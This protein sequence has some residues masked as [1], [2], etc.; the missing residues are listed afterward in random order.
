M[1]QRPRL[2]EDP[3]LSY[4]EVLDEEN[5]ALTGVAPPEA[6]R[7]LRDEHKRALR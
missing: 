7:L 2:E 4:L 5:S 1:M 6:D 3:P